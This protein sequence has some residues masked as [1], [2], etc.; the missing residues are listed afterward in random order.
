MTQNGHNDENVLRCDGHVLRCDY[1][2][3]WCDINKLD[4]LF[5]LYLLFFKCYIY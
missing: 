1:P 5:G 2:V 4:V 3:L